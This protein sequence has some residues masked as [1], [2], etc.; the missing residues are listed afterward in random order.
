MTK[1]ASVVRLSQPSCT[2]PVGVALL[3]SAALPSAGLLAARAN[4]RSERLSPP[5]PRPVPGAQR[6]RPRS[7]AAGRRPDH[8]RQAAADW[9]AAARAGFERIR[10]GD[11]Y[12]PSALRPYKQALNTK[13]LSESS[14]RRASARSCRP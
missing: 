13:L 4:G 8:D 3:A 7:T 12:K 5:W 11:P 1:T 14:G 10:S 6:P 2:D 9:L